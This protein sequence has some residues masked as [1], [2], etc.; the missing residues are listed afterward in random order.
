MEKAWILVDYSNFTDFFYFRFLKNLRAET[1]EPQS[2]LPSCSTQETRLSSSSSTGITWKDAQMS[3]LPCLFPWAQT[4][5]GKFAKDGVK[6]P[7]SSILFSP[8]KWGTVSGNA[9][10]PAQSNPTAKP[11]VWRFPALH[12]SCPAQSHRCLEIK[13]SD[14]D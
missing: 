1:E 4:T 11:S 5:L 6:F 3:A 7:L 8:L 14:P 2:L 9:P 10:C 13:S 12:S